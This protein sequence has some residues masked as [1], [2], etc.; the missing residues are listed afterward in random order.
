MM[1][2][3]NG[4]DYPFI[5]WKV[6]IHSCSSHHQ[7]DEYSTFCFQHVSSLLKYRGGSVGFIDIPV[8]LIPIA[9]KVKESSMTS[10]GRRMSQERMGKGD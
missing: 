8:F 2:F 5:L 10:G 3:V 4:K 9:R 1:E 6:I 7:P